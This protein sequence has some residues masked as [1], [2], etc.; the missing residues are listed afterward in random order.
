MNTETAITKESVVRTCMNLWNSPLIGKLFTFLSKSQSLVFYVWFHARIILSLFIYIRL[1]VLCF[2]SCSDVNL[3]RYLL[4]KSIAD[5]ETGTFALPMPSFGLKLDIK[6][7]L[8]WKIKW[9]CNM[10]TKLSLKPV[11]SSKTYLFKPGFKPNL[12]RALV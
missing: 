11:V 12:I 1:T 2:C 5:I 3:S 10:A 6:L 8:I 4:E 9:R 7:Y